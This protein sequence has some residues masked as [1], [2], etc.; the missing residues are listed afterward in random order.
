MGLTRQ[1]FYDGICGLL[2]Q[3]NETEQAM[4]DFDIDID[5]RASMINLVIPFECFDFDKEE[6]NG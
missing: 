5:N 3:L 1:Q 6:E 2:D 4:G